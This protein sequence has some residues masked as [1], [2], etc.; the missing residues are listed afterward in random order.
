MLARERTP[1][2]RHDAPGAAAVG[3][4]TRAR[5]HEP[6]RIRARSSD[7]A[8]PRRLV[9]SASSASM[10]SGDGAFSPPSAA[11]Y[12]STWSAATHQCGNSLHARRAIRAIESLLSVSSSAKD[13][14]VR[15]EPITRAM[16]ICARGGGRGRDGGR[17]EVSASRGGARRASGGDARGHAPMP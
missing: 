15:A 8:S 12:S 14:A 17:D 16:K 2:S 1:A 10:D 7:H 9:G 11:R 6:G 3:G 13:P 5:S 4:G